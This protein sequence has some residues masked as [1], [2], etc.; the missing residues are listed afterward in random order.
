MTRPG[1]RRLLPWA[2]TAPLIAVVALFGGARSANGA[3]NQPGAFLLL[4]SLPGSLDSPLVFSAVSPWTSLGQALWLAALAA[5]GTTMT[6]TAVP[7]GSGRFGTRAS[8]ADAVEIL[9]W[10]VPIRRSGG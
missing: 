6:G 3:A 4:P 8:C 5:R 2:L 10:R 7:S 1:D 9:R